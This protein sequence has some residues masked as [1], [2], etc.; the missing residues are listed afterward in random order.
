MLES[1]S[2]EPGLHPAPHTL[3]LEGS[4]LTDTIEFLQQLELSRD[5]PRS[6]VEKP[7]SVGSA[8]LAAAEY[9]D[10]RDEGIA[11]ALRVQDAF[12]F[13]RFYTTYS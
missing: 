12:D 4:F 3:D 11:S 8:G 7:I 1:T 6:S 9:R 10:S 5:Q 2:P 13:F